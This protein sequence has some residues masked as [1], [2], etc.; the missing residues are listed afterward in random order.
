MND[1]AV[2]FDGEKVLYRKTDQ[3]TIA[4]TAEPPAADAQAEA[5]R[6]SAE[7]RR[8]WSCG[9]SPCRVEADVSR[10]LADRARLLLRPA[11]S[12]TRSVEVEKKYEPYLAGL[13]SRAE[14]N[15]LLEEMLGEMT[16]GHMF[17]GG[18]DVPSRRSSKAG[19]S[20]RTTTLENGRYRF[21]RVYSGENWN[22]GSAGAADAAGR[23]REG[24]RVHPRR[25]TDAN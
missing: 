25:C 3:W 15:Y 4:G 6:R 18:G 23:Q 22:P 17:I 13:A 14:L 24:G 8:A 21:A 12:R 1:F 11:A 2:S 7:A 10:G 5:G 20:A 19:C 9:S 16:V